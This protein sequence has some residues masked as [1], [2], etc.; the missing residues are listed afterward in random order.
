MTVIFVFDPGK[1]EMKITTIQ[2]FVNH[3][4]DISAPI[5]VPGFLQSNISRP[6]IFFFRHKLPVQKKGLSAIKF[7][8]IAD[9]HSNDIGS[10]K[11]K[12]C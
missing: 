10:N 4:Y 11:K 2:I 1:S 9:H 12:C 5:A 6:D 8:G 7:N 3:S